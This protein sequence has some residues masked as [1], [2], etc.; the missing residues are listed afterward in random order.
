MELAQ[1]MNPNTT[2]SARTTSC[3]TR[4]GGSDWVGAKAC[5]DGIFMND[6]MTPT[7]KSR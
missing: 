4:N 2:K 7:K 5:S 6:W 1:R 3:A